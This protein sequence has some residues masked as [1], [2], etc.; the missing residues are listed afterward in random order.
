MH[1]FK[2]KRYRIKWNAK[3]RKF[4]KKKKNRQTSRKA[5]MRWKK[6]KSTMKAALRRSK[7]KR[8]RSM[9]RNKARGMYKKLKRARKQFKS[10]LKHDVEYD[11][12]LNVLMEGEI[13]EVEIIVEPEDID[14]IKEA[15]LDLRDNLEFD[16]DDELEVM[17]FIEDS[18]ELLD[19]ISGEELEDED[20]EALQD[21][22]GV[23]D[24]YA[25]MAGIYDE[26]DE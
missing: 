13:P 22:L 26:E 2:F 20:I 8:K 12:I 15:L 24:D 18:E 25:E 1:P 6:N 21:I 19:N 7:A 11:S 9:K 17:Q 4:L 3:K 16:S 23:I 14:G 5:Y 10:F